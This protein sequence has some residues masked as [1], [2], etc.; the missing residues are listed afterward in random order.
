ML[1][2]SDWVFLAPEDHYNPA[3]SK[4]VWRER[5]GI[6]VPVRLMPEDSI[7][8]RRSHKE[9]FPVKLLTVVALW[10]VQNGGGQKSQLPATGLVLS[11]G[12]LLIAERA[13]EQTTDMMFIS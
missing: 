2:I 4:V 5:N 6:A 9:Y 11:S 3:V 13:S 10:G 1:P 8:A 7:V 12:R